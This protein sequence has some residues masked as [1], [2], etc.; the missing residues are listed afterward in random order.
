MPAVQILL[1]FY[2][3]YPSGEGH[4]EVASQFESWPVAKRSQG[5]ILWT[6]VS[7]FNVGFCP[8]MSSGRRQLC[9]AGGAKMAKIMFILQR[10]PDQTHD[11][12]MQ[13]WASPGHTSIVKKIPSVTKW[14]QNQVIGGP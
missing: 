1:F 6:A 9:K 3:A 7:G 5:F 13:Y 10:R 4:G 12:C 11:E 2:Q 14:V 8:N